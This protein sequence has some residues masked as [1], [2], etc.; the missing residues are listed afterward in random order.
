MPMKFLIASVFGLL[1]AL[2]ARRALRSQIVLVPAFFASW[3]VIELAPQLLLLLGSGV[4]VFAIQG[5]LEEWPGWV[6]IGIAAVTAYLLWGMVRESYRSDEVFES[7][8]SDA[9]GP[10]KARDLVSWR[11]FAFPFKLWTRRVHRVRNIPYIEGGRRRM[12]LDIWKDT[13]DA[14]GRPC[15][16]YVPG[17]AWM[18]GISNKNQQGKPLL[19]EMATKGWLCFAIN[20]PVS[21]RAR[22]PEHIVAV[23]RAIAWIKEHAHEYGGDPGFLMIA[24]NSAGGH[25]SSLAALSANDPDYQPGFEDADTSVQA[26]V[27]L[28]GIYD[29]TGELLEEL[30]RTH[31]RHK[32]GMLRYLETLVVKQKLKE[33]RPVF[34]KGSPLLRARED[35]PPF[36]VIHGAMDTLALVHEARAFA[37]RLRRTSREPVV[38]AEL[39][40]AQHAF[41]QF[42]SIRTIYTVRAI[43]RFGD[44]AFERWRAAVRDPG[45]TTLRRGRDA[46]PE[47]PPGQ[48]ARSPTSTT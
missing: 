30:S 47:Q 28:Y 21:P 33:G 46:P 14:T 2:N 41:D 11:H 24:G 15:L 1:L 9:I 4:A 3:L 22:F 8:L 23:K 35:A 27:P 44:W 13:S 43:A 45:P 31:R 29:L 42:L 40:R 48:A 26:A 7:A 34:E 17:G 19:I 6:A 25:L 12:R 37:D 36:F 32:A 10:R 38:Y 18:V 5:G 16:L 39:P 20:Y